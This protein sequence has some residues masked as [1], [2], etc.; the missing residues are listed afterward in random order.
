MKPAAAVDYLF[1]GAGASASLLLLELERTGQLQGKSVVLVDPAAQASK[2][3]TFCFWAEDTDPIAVHLGSLVS[4]TWD[5][6]AL[7]GE[8]SQSLFPLRY[9]HISSL[10]LYRRVQELA[11]KYGW[12]RYTA[13]ADEVSADE[14]GPFA[15]VEGTQF[16]AK[17]L[18]DSR[19]PV[20]RAPRGGEVHM[21]QS[22][23]GWLIQ[24]DVPL[25]DP[26][27]FRFMDFQIPQQGSTQFVYA[28]P[29]SATTVLVEVTRFGADQIQADDANELLRSYIHQHYGS[30]AL[31]EVE[32]GCIPMST[33]GLEQPDV[34]GIT[35]LGARNYRI[36]PSTG[37]AF[38]N[39]YSQASDLARALATG[40]S[41]EA[42]NRSHADA[43]AGRF[44]FYDGLL[45][46]ILKNQPHRG[47]P[48]FEALL[49]G[50]ETPRIMRFL[51]EKTRF[52]EE[53]SLFW[54]LPWRPFLAAAGKKI[55]Q[56]PT[57]R[58]V[59][60]ALLTLLFLLLSPLPAVQSSVA[61]GLFALGLIAVGIPHGAVDHLLDSGQSRVTPLFVLRYL[62]L[63]AAMGAVW[64]LTPVGAL[65]LFLG[66]SAWHFGQ[67]DGN[68][69]NLRPFP[70]FLW[71]LFVLFYVLGTHRGET[72]A[73]LSAMGV[74]FVGAESG[75]ASLPVWASLPALGLALSRRNAAF[76]WTVLWLTLASQLPLLM[77]FGLYFLGQHSLNGWSDLRAHLQLSNRALWL[78][79]LPFHAG[80][81]LLLAGFWFFWPTSGPALDANRW[82]IFFVFLS[83]ISF[84]HTVYMHT[85]Y[86]KAK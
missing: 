74:S 28:L 51:D 20:H 33:A 6:V 53:I 11:L 57:A 23:V 77:A 30:F 25:E 66:Y 43:I 39:M 24:T 61:Y 15:W 63:T 17:H 73:I 67:A 32:T 1:C 21:Y 69:W 76:V 34:P 70:S 82:A 49:S 22:F 36:K 18:F 12:T 41:P 58:P 52:W 83:C 85:V 38:K 55:L 56:A 45:L 47:K 59:A 60:L 44:S 50:V 35:R 84:P 2:D 81:W 46:D 7:A 78:Q 80:A 62:A 26:T 68:R 29:F 71:G 72:D 27:S 8:S 31:Q 14:H 5:R 54:S 75:P 4:H 19:T 37:Y 13:P 9:R 16:R 48:I 64:L 79:A 10:D 3:K 42:Q 65:A 40:T 86:A